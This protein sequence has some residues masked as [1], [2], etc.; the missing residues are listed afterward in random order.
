MAKEANPPILTA[1]IIYQNN[2]LPLFPHNAQIFLQCK[3]KIV[4]W[5]FSF[6]KISLYLAVPINYYK[7][8]GFFD[9]QKQRWNIWV[10]K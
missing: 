5:F 2:F 6:V 8:Q 1:L 9:E 7:M 3:M 10:K 4:L